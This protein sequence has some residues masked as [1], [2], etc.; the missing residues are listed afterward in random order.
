MKYLKCACVGLAFVYGGLY[1]MFFLIGLVLR[2]VARPQGQHAV[3][4]II[5]LRSPMVWLSTLVFF[6]CGYFWAYRRFSK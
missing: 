1:A 2:M 5:S 4:F 3:D 6:G